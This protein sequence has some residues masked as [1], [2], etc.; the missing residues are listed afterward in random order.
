MIKWFDFCLFKARIKGMCSIVSSSG[1]DLGVWCPERHGCWSCISVHIHH[2]QLAS[3]KYHSLNYVKM[4]RNHVQST[5]IMTA[6]ITVE[7]PLR[8]HL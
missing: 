5:A 2:P 4:S 6:F 8:G 7:P 3:G 1:N